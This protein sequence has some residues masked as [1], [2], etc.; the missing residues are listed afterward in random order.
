MYIYIGGRSTDLTMTDGTDLWP[1]RTVRE[2]LVYYKFC[3]LRNPSCIIF[4]LV[5][6]TQDTGLYILLCS[7]QPLLYSNIS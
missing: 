3:S 4:F 6:V 2:E 5:C 7:R 1:W